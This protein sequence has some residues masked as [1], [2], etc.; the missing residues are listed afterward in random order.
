MHLRTLTT[1]DAPG[2]I[3]LL[4][5]LDQESEFMLFEPGER[6]MSEEAQRERITAMQKVDT[7][8]VFAA[9]V[10]GQIVGFLGSTAGAQRR[11]R[12]TASLVVGVLKAFQGRG[13]GSALLTELG[14]WARARQVHRLELTVMTHNEAALKLYQKHGFSVEGTRKDALRVGEAFVHEYYMGKIIE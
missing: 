9:E 4:Q 2:F 11:S 1:N 3:L 7:Q 12:H 8:V 13:I 6:V 14:H 10:E 5:K